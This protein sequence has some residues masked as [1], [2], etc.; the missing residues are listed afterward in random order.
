MGTSILQY[1]HLNISDTITV[2]EMKAEK[3]EY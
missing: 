1:I 2:E 3:N